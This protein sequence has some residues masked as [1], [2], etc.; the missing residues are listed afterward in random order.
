MLESSSYEYYTGKSRHS[1][2][3]RLS[4]LGS[5]KSPTNIFIRL[6]GMLHFE[7]YLQPYFVVGDMCWSAF[8]APFV[9]IIILRVVKPSLLGSVCSFTLVYYSF[10]KVPISFN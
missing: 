8:N 10:P 1:T 2:S 6:H 3:R 9:L 7:D 5:M 4:N